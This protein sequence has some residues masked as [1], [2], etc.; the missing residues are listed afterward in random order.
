MN[1]LLKIVVKAGTIHVA[2]ANDLLI[3]AWGK[4]TRNLEDNGNQTL[5]IVNT[6]IWSVLNNIQ[7]A[8]DKS[9]VL[10]LIKPKM[11]KRPPYF[12]LN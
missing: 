9:V 8:Q 12:K 6:H 5:Q 2:Y 7:I 10:T 3:I 1:G 11:L 4:S